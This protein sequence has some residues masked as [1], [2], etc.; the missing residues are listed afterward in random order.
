MVSLGPNV[1]VPY[2][3]RGF[4]GEAPG[5]S[6]AQEI[7]TRS[8]QALAVGVA[9]EVGIVAAV[10]VAEGTTSGTA[11]VVLVVVAD[12]GT[13]EDLILVKRLGAF[14]FCNGPHNCFIT[15]SLRVRNCHRLHL[16]RDDY[17][18]FQILKSNGVHLNLS[19]LYC[20]IAYTFRHSLFKFFFN[21]ALW[22]L[23]T[24]LYF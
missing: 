19:L 18:F 1:D 24:V 13:L 10:V 22:D 8:F 14:V 12:D 3:H 16:K 5:Q 11:V 21:L 23:G 4:F 6:R 17:F 2:Q 15:A 7:G 20:A 9:V